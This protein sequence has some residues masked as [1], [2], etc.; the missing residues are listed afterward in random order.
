MRR[1]WIAC[2]ILGVAVVFV[3]TALATYSSPKVTVAQTATTT[4]LVASASGTDDATGFVA[5][6]IPAGTTITANQK[7]GATIGVAKARFNA[8]ALGGAALALQGPITVAAPGS[9]PPTQ[10]A[11]CIQT[12]T[13]LAT[14]L[15]GLSAGGKTINLPAYLIK[16]VA[17]EKAVFGVAKLVF[18]LA[19]P[20]L[21]VDNGG[22]P[23][24]AKFLSAQLAVNGV[25]GAAT[26][27]PFYTAWIPWL[28]GAGTR[29]VTQYSWTATQVAPATI[30]AKA[31]K[32]GNGAVVAGLVTQGGKPRAG[33]RVAIFAST[34]RTGLKKVGVVKTGAAGTFSYK[35]ASGAYF[36]AQAT[37]PETPAP[38][39]CAKLKETLVNAR[40]LNPIVSPA[41]LVSAVTPRR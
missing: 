16:T 29:D 21:P 10:Q 11:D 22:A 17:Q 12:E 14:W 3:G 4:T 35:A 25:F 40:C 19:P 37:L 15:I 24:G 34:S 26:G 28:A 30:T 41:L 18:C 6:Y 39:L 36:R 2:A 32:S 27:G 31:K 23:F 7:P 20:D 9:V 33:A 13:P 8:L 38:E 5:I 1:G